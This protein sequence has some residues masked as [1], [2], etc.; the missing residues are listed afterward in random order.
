[1]NTNQ[2]KGIVYEKY[3]NS[4]LNALS[5]TKISYL[6]SDVPE[7]ILFEARLI[8]NYNKH[9]LARKNDE[10]KIN[11]LKDVGIDIIQITTT[12]NIVFVQCKNYSLT[13]RVFD[14]FYYIII[15]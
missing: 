9:R 15:L 8:T 13:L 4:Y 5:E 14:F 3:I 10:Y 11:R 2:E 6:W 7:Q 1:M 12:G